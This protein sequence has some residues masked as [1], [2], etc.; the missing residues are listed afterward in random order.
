MVDI[1]DGRGCIAFSCACKVCNKQ[2]ITLSHC[3]IWSYF[4]RSLHVNSPSAL[5]NT[6][7]TREI[8]RYISH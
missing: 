8:T 6:D 4:T 3:E 1:L 2:F 7:A 5:E